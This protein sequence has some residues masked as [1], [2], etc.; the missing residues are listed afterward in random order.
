M[1]N[2]AFSLNATLPVFL[3]MALGLV[4]RKLRVIDDVFA[5]KM[6]GFV[7][8]VCL[9][10]LLFSDI[11]VVDLD[12]GWNG[13]LVLFCLGATCASIALVSA[14]A[15]LLRSTSERGEF[16]QGSYRSSAAL[17]G[18][19]NMYGEADLA[20]LMIIGAVPLYNVAAVFVLTLTAP[21]TSGE[22][23]LSAGLKRAVRGVV[24][25]P[26][27]IGIAAGFAYAATGL[28]MPGLL[29][30]LTG[31]I[32]GLATPLGLLAMGAMFDF[33]RAAQRIKPALAASS[34]KLVGLVAAFLP[35][36]VA[37][38]FRGE[39]LAVILVMLGSGTTVSS[40]VM[41][42][43]SGHE[44]VLSS[45][46]VMMTTFGSAFTLTGWVFVLRSLGLV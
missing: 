17:L 36:A 40:F 18:V 5:S 30:S 15:L 38:G 6:N 8:S 37:C 24:T 3:L 25:N 20:A 23:R 31:S 39:E 42:R 1:D 16:I 19:Q 32:G 29:G 13:R 35:V 26:I 2:L 45:T 12:T 34:L 21:G 4:L 28:P 41:A 43:A 14:L 7:F 33:R 11:A 10:V 27:L 9:P 44:G 46:I 22:E